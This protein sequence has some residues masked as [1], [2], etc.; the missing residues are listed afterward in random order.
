VT[1]ICKPLLFI[2]GSHA[3]KY[4]A[5]F[6]YSYQVSPDSWKDEVATKICTRFTTLGEIED[7][8]R[9]IRNY[10]EGKLACEI[11]PA[12]ENK[13]ITVYRRI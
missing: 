2:E 6:R 11:S 9:D 8:F 10:P 5:S 4:V 7:W 3:K 13:T 1:Y 12:E